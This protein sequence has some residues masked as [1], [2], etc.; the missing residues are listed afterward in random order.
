MSP[1]SRACDGSMS[2]TPQRNRAGTSNQGNTYA[3]GQAAQH[4]FR[5]VCQMHNF[6][7]ALKMWDEYIVIT[8]A[9]NSSQA[10][11]GGLQ[12]QS[13]ARHLHSFLECAAYSVHCLADSYGGVV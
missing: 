10:Q 11:P 4:Q 7:N 12:W 13:A 1:S 2:I 8:G 6:R 3:T 5:V 9:I